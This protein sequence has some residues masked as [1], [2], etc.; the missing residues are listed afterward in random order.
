MG[1]EQNSPAI[2]ID[3]GIIGYSK[4][5]FRGNCNRK[6]S[7]AASS[8]LRHLWWNSNDA[9]QVAI[10]NNKKIHNHKINLVLLIMI[11]GLIRTLSLFNTIICLH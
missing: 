10:F 7:K 3:G 6:D 9:L 5:L 11:Q 1:H 2:D 8:T 4:A